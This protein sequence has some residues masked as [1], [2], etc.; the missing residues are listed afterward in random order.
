MGW[1][2]GYDRKWNRDIGYSVPAPCDFPKC[3]KIIDRGLSY[4]CG[5]DPYGGEF[6]CGLYF[7][8][9]HFSYRTPRGSRDMVQNCPR[10]INYRAPYDP[11]PDCAEWIKWKLTD[12][13][14]AEWRAE[15]KEEVESLS[16]ILSLPH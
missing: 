9:E 12:E 14:W 10:C 15:N 13:S 16:K 2:I 8:S 7:C 5:S 11:K 4:V 1:S 6:G 3:D